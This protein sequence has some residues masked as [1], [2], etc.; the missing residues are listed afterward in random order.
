MSSKCYQLAFALVVVA[1]SQIIIPQAKSSSVE[2][3]KVG[4]AEKNS[5]LEQAEQAT[6]L[7]PSPPP[8]VNWTPPTQ[9][10]SDSSPKSAK[11]KRSLNPMGW[12]FNPVTKLEQQSL[13]LQQQQIQLTNPLG[14]LL[15]AILSLQR[16]GGA[17]DRELTG[18]HSDL[19]HVNKQLV[20]IPHKI[21]AST[22]NVS[23]MEETIKL[24]SQQI[25]EVRLSILGTYKELKQ[26]RPDFTCVRKDIRDIHD[27]ILRLE[28]PIAS[29]SKPIN[30]LDKEVVG[31]QGEISHLR[32]PLERLEDPV[33]R[34]SLQLTD[35]HSE[36]HELHN[37][38]RLILASIFVAAIIVA[39]GTP[40]AA[41]MI[42]RNKRAVKSRLMSQEPAGTLRN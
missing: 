35:L 17:I 13:R 42:W 26:M 11:P 7:A 31:L 14:Q 9:L 3:S 22:T 15:P 18:V 20:A 21:D 40:V 41:V 32:G 27:P 6:G 2:D 38:L 25:A 37:E 4:L 1:Y 33:T 24:L 30:N 23:R 8:P 19:E 5:D 29:L 10:D 28:T 12:I 16:H 36:L 39:F 34:L